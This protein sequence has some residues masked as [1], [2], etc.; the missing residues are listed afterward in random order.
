MGVLRARSLGGVL[1]GSLLFG[2]IVVASVIAGSSPAL[3]TTSAPTWEQLSPATSPSARELAS[4]AN[5]AGTGQLVLFGGDVGGNPSDDTWTWNGTTW[6]QQSPATSPPVRWGASMA[7]NPG[8]GQLVLFGGAYSPGGNDTWAWN[9][10][11]WTQQ[12][13]ATSPPAREWASMD[14][15]AGTGQL[16]LFGGLGVTSDLN[17]T[18]LA[19]VT[20]I[21]TVS[22]VYPHSGPTAGGTAITITGSGFVTG[23]TVEIGQGYGAGPT[24]IAATN[25][26]VVSPTEITAVTGGGAKAGTFSLFV[27]TTGGTNAANTGAD[28]SYGVTVSKVRPNTGPTSGGTTITITGTGFVA[29]ATEVIGQ[30]NGTTGAIAATSVKVVSPTEITAVTG[31]RAKAGTF[32]LFVT[33]TEGTSAANTGAD[34][35]YGVTVTKVSPNTGPTSGG[36]AITITG[37]GFVAGATVVIGQGNGTTGAIA[38]TSV[39]VVSSTEIT[40]VTGGGAKAGTFSLFVTTSAGTSAASTGADFTYS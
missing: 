37:T 8:T 5:D 36:T 33:T 25:V 4:M 38:A 29:G 32:S 10:T 16:V 31:G 1:A 14:Y 26:T 6:T 12:S 24:A 13:P 2:G 20:S 17:D 9:G 11:T 22:A 27:T 15:D 30:G 28:F 34:F 39:K 18:W 19:P 23:A 3:A 21:P 40:A 35:S 7:Y